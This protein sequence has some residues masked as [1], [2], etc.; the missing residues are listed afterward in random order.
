MVPSRFPPELREPLT[1][2]PPGSLRLEVGIQT[3]NRETAALIGRSC[4]PEAELEALSFLGTY[5]NAIIHADLIVGLPEE[6]LASFGDGF[7]RLW[8]AGPGEI[9]VGILKRLPGTPLARRGEAWGMRYSPDP[10][11]EVLGTAALPAR[12]LDRLKNFARFWELIVNR[13][14]FRDL[15]PRLFPQGRRVFRSFL[16]LSDRLLERFGRNWG[17]DRRDLHAELEKHF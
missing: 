9:Q 1:R 13:G 5:T 15:G 3:F 4:A 10:P 16:E 12:E 14:A 8:L 7:D 6:D 2:F 17:I 11:Y